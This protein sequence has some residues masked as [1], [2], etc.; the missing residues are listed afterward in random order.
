MMSTTRRECFGFGFAGPPDEPDIRALVGSTPMPGAVRVRFEREPN[1]FHGCDV[2]G[3][4]CQV[5]IARHRPDGALAGILCRSEQPAYVNGSAVRIGGIGQLRIAARYRGRHLLQQGWPLFEDPDLVYLALVA[6]EN[7]AALR[8]L[9]H[10]APHRPSVRQLGEIATMG[11]LV[12]R[13]RERRHQRTTSIVRATP[14][15][16]EELVAFLDRE[17]RRRQFTPVRTAAALTSPRFRGLA[18]EDVFVAREGRRIVGCM[19]CWDQRA[20]KQDVVDGYG[21]VLSRARPGIDALARVYGAAPLPEPGQMLQAASAALVAVAEDDPGVFA[22]LVDACLEDAARRGVDW[23]MLG[24]ADRD[25]LRRVARRHLHVTYRARLF[26]L[27]WRRPP[28]ALDG[29]CPYVEI[30][31]L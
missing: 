5:L 1:Y 2:M 21:A 24:L 22:H 27:T 29:R 19:A 17:G 6:R 30:A 28:P 3:E 4:V 8:V 31:A 9:A 20:Y 16:L 13:G 15:S 10:H 11:L 23:L 12:R 26:A 18:P 25:P 14:D 7:T